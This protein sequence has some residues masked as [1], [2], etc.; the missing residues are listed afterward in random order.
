MSSMR[1]AALFAGMPVLPFRAPQGAASL[2]GGGPV[3]ELMP[4]A[5]ALREELAKSPRTE[6]L[7]GVVPGG[8]VVDAGLVRVGH[9]PL[10][11]LA[12]EEGVE[13][14]GDRRGEVLH[15]T[16]RDDAQGAHA[17]RSAVEDQGLP[18]R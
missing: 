11:D 18:A 6:R 17:L 15:R 10:G 5:E 8:D 1:R 16:A 13:A 12:G 9:D 2:D 3:D 4:G 14:V 7:R